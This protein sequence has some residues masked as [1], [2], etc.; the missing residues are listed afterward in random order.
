M[1][2]IGELLFVEGKPEAGLVGVEVR[3]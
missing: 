3:L 2:Q 1:L